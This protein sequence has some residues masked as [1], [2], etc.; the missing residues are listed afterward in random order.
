MRNGKTDPKCRRPRRERSDGIW[1]RRR[2]RGRRHPDRIPRA[3]QGEGGSRP[4][5]RRVDGEVDRDLAIHHDRQLRRG[6]RARRRGRRPGVRGGRRGPRHASATFFARVDASAKP[7]AIVATVSSGLSIAAMCAGQ[8][9]GFRTH[10]LGIHFFNPPTVI[11]GCELIPHAG[12]DPAV[13]AFVRELLAGPLGR[14]VVETSDTPAFAGNRVGFKVLNE[15]AQL[16]EEH[17]V[18]FMDQLVGP[19]SGRA[20]APLVTDRL[21][22][23]GRAQGD[24][25]QPLREHEGRGAR[26]VQAARVHAA[27]HRCRPPRQQDRRPASSRRTARRQLV[28]DPKSGDYRPLAEVATPLPAFVEQMK[29]A[30]RVGRYQRAMDAFCD[31]D[32][33]RSRAA[34]PGRARL[35]QLRPQPRRRG[36]A[37]TRATSIASWALASTGRRRACWSM[38]SARAARSRCSSRRKLAGAARARRRRRN[39][40]STSSTSPRSIAGASSSPRREEHQTMVYILGGFQTDFARNWTK[41]G[42]HISAMIREAVEGCLAATGVAP[43]VDRRRPRRQLRRRALLDAGASRRVP[44]RRRPRVRGPADRPPRGGLRVGLDRAARRRP[45]E[46]EA[47]RYDC[48][49]VVGVE[50]MKTVVAGDR[51]RLSRHRRLVRARGQGRR[52]PVPEAVRQAR[53]RVRPA[54]RPQG[55]APRAHRRRQLRQREEEP[56]G[57]D[58]HLVHERGRTPARRRATTR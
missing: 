36:R 17:G 54:L 28:L 43:Q 29:S 19:H 10:F 13:T 40:P 24:R 52:V 32:G 7:D 30:I 25:R 42:K 41:E 6:S 1:K 33:R 21:R 37:A 2:L 16:A 46:I 14:E 31:A 55:R 22:R 57:A 50:Q 18:A 51:R 9:D 5:A 27:R 48:A 39:E 38:R 47:G 11:V 34:A 20:M 12:T 44:R 49:L 35:H 4:R 15:V 58:P 3:H 8:S 45:P 23:L 56:E 26:G 53:R